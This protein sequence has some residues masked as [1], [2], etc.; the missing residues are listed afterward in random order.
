[1]T[2]TR[3]SDNFNDRAYF[4]ELTRSARLLHVEALVWCNG[5][6]T[7][8]I[9]PRHM[10]RRITDSLDVDSD[11]A[12]L[13]AA[14]LWVQE[15]KVWQIDWTDQETA[16]K[17]QERREAEARKKRRQRAHNSGDH[18]FC[19]PT[20]CWVLTGK[21]PRDTPGDTPG[22]TPRESRGVSR[23][24]RPDPDPVPSPKDGEDE[25]GAGAALGSAARPDAEE[26]RVPP[27][28]AFLELKA[29]RR[30]EQAEAAAERE[31]QRQAAE[32]DYAARLAA[33]QVKAIGLTPAQVEAERLE[34]EQRREAEQVE[35]ESA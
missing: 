26:E 29:Q 8:G 18:S 1:M 22:D 6:E 25:E 10:L 35:E 2:W 16:D 17:V 14:G 9:L 20:R 19:D 30:Q 12:E 31:R 4:A 5:E 24:S 3:L 32:A 34:A 21:S 33:G 27:S 15:G 13:E 23:P 28:A 7:D 11:V